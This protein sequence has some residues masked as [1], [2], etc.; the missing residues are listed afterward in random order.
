MKRNLSFLL[1]VVLIAVTYFVSP[2]K[3]SA[4]SLVKKRTADINDEP[5]DWFFR[6]RAYPS[7]NISYEAYHAAVMQAM[8]IKQTSTMRTSAGTSL[9]WQFAGPTNIGGRVT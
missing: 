9:A 8:A 3:R 1:L 6:Q 2:A 7:G 5:N 4:T